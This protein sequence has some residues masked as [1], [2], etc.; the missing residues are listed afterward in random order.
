MVLRREGGALSAPFTDLPDCCRRSAFH[1]WLR[2]LSS[3]T[4]PGMRPGSNPL[5][6]RPAAINEDVRAGDE[7]GILGAEV[8]R[9]LTDFLHATPAVQRNF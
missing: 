2:G 3:S 1:L 6:R 8:N 7:T 5:L 9:Q 4:G